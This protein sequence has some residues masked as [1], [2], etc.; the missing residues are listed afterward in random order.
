MNLDQF[1]NLDVKIL[2]GTL[3]KQV[4][5]WDET[6]GNAK[7][8]RENQVSMEDGFWQDQRDARNRA[9]VLADMF[10]E[11]EKRREA[12]AVPLG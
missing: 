9:E 7:W 12:Q 11:E 10:R 6:W 4:Q 5:K 2:A 3:R 8:R 1:T